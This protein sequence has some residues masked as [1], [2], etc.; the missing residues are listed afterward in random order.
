MARGAAVRVRIARIEATLTLV[1]N[2]RTLGLGIVEYLQN[3]EAPILKAESNHRIDVQ[4]HPLN[5][6]LPGSARVKP[7]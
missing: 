6:L 4:N 5:G 1:S 2:A 7:R 3:I